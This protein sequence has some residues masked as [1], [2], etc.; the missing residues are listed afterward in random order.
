MKATCCSAEVL[1]AEA[2]SRGTSAAFSVLRAW[3]WSR[4]LAMI[5]ESLQCWE[6]P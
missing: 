4:A 5:T 3:G 1:W 6:A 2:Q